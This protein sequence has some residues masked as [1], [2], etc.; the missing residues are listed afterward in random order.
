MRGLKWNASLRSKNTPTNDKAYTTQQ[1]GEQVQRKQEMFCPRGFRAF[2][3]FKLSTL[4]RQK[5]AIAWRMPW[6][7]GNF[8]H[9]L[10]R[11]ADKLQYILKTVA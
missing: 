8:S 11:C 3:I 4:A 7:T 2:E 9:R 1:V 10:L 5:Y 6:N